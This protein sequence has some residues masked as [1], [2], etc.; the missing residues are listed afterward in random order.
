[1]QKK[2]ASS[3]CLGVPLPKGEIVLITDASDVGGGG[4]IYQ[5]QELNPAE[6]THCHY[7]TSGLN[8]DGSLKH[9]YPSSEWRLVQLGQ[10]NWKWNQAP[11][12]HSTY[13]QEL[14]AGMLVL[15]SQSRILGSNPIVRPRDQEPLK[16]FQKGPPPKKAKLKQWWTYLGQFRLTV[17]HNPGIKNEL[18]D[19]I[20]R[21]NFDALIG[22]SS[23]GLAKEAFQRMDVQL[24]LSMQTAVTLDGWRLTDYQSEYKEILQTLSTG[25]EPRVIDGH[26]WYQKN[27]YL[28]YEERIVVPDA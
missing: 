14:L 17:H 22:E 7:R 20:S 19:Y 10:W 18:S 9:D 11:S 5:W 13:D 15:S 26:Q 28:F 1:M 4:T 3:N 21:N 2:I 27:D 16:S 23:E 8:R 12:N 6:L 24:D 25:L